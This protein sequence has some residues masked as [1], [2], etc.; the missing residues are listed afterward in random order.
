MALFLTACFVVPDE[1]CA[2]V[3]TIDGETD[4]ARVS[5]IDGMVE[6][7]VAAYGTQGIL[8]MSFDPAEQADGV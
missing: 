4:E 3:S 1:D 5:R 8:S 6:G 2:Y 7:M